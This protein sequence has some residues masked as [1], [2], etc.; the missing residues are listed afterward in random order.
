MSIKY[1]NKCIVGFLFCLLSGGGHAQNLN[2]GYVPNDTIVAEDVIVNVAFQKKSIRDVNSAISTVQGHEFS[3]TPVISADNALSG[4]LSGVIPMSQPDAPGREYVDMYIRGLHTSSA[5]KKPMILVDN[6]ERDFSQ[7][8]LNEIESVTVLKDAAAAALYGG[9]AANGVVLI[10]TKRGANIGRQELQLNV[11]GAM[12]QPTRLPSYLNS[13]DYARLYD[14][15]Y[16]MDGNV[17]PFYGTEKIEGYRKVV[18]GDPEANPYLYPNNNYYDMGLRDF[19]WQQ[20]YDLSMRGGNETA[21]YFVLLGYLQQDG[22][23][24]YEDKSNDYNTNTNYRRFNVRT[25][26]DMKINNVISASLDMAGR[27]EYRHGAG[28]D[29]GDI[30]GQMAATPANAY[31]MFNE[32]GS[33]GGTARYTNNIYGMITRT[34]YKDEQ[35]RLFNATASVN[36]DLDQWVQGLKLGIRG[37]FDYND[38]FHSNRIIPGYRVYELQPDGSYTSYGEDKTIEESDGVDQEYRTYLFQGTVNYNR[39]FRGKHNISALGHFMMDTKNSPGNVPDYKNVIWGANLSYNYM[40][41]YYVDLTAG[42]SGTELYAPGHRFRFYPAA[43]VGWTLS[44]EDFLKDNSIINYLK[45]RASY[46]K[47]GLDR[48]DDSNRFLW[49]SSWGD[50]TGYPFGPT[51]TDQSGQSEKSSAN[52]L[53]HGETAYKMN[54]GFDMALFDNRLYLT[55]DYF[56]ERREDIMLQ[57]GR[58]IPG[59]FGVNL[60]YENL[61]RVDSKGIEGGIT[62]TDKLGKDFGFT[63]GTNFMYTTNEVKEMYEEEKDWYRYSKG[64]PLNQQFGLICDGFVTQEDLQNPD[65]P[66]H[67]FG[68]LREGDL[69]YKDLNGDGVV[70]ENDKTYIGK[71]EIPEIIANFTLG[72]TWKNFEVSLLFQGMFNKNLRKPSDLYIPFRDGTGNATKYAFE[73]WTPETAETAKYPRMSTGANNMGSNSNNGQES[74]FWIISGDF[75]RLKNAVIAYNLPQKWLN[76]VGIKAAKVYLSGYNL[77]TFDGVNDIDPEIPYW[78]AFWKYPNNRTYS[79]G[80][81]ITF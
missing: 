65:F 38:I 6:V 64:H 57:R 32:D 1:N 28:K 7:L 43:A 75:V 20:N 25:N 4:H 14:T 31:P 21:Q 46:G 23:Y 13:Y 2:S 78:T 69:K 59:I 70:D 11:Q 60:P 50:D 39:T 74:D 77:L 58:D 40:H 30:L 29:A 26:L 44:E 47:N 62:Y 9:R 81:N 68:T 24:K 71:A 61:G 45:V 49:R 33:L 63:I 37:G 12:V 3:L 22:L 48:I 34:G 55:G 36:F 10:T 15:A 35:R 72:F 56:T 53:L 5:N 76:R 67:T 54:I 8:N 41:K 17:N 16:M 19:S 52:V 51:V 18:E 42:Y 80:M 73:C 66:T 79:F 27:L